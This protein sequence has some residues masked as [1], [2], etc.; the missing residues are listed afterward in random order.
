MQRLMFL[1]CFVQKLSK[2]TFGEVGSTQPPL[3]KGKVNHPLL[4]LLVPTPFTKG[5][6]GGGS[7][8]PPY[9]LINRCSH[10]L[11]ILIGY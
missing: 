4:R 11:E 1:N 7:A 6:G 8:G 9:Y 3:E 5:G 10:D 2:K